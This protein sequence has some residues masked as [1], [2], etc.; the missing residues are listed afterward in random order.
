MVGS[1]ANGGLEISAAFDFSSNDNILVFS[2][3]LP[4]F[5]LCSRAYEIGWGKINREVLCH[6][7]KMKSR[8]ALWGLP[9]AVNEALL[10]SDC[11][12]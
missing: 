4:H 12:A 2:P 1:T 9:A 3:S 10:T 6:Y 8:R 5:G 7:C 11:I